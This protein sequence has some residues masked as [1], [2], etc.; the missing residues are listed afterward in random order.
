M[1]AR[2]F[3]PT[4]PKAVLFDMDDTIFDHSLTCRDALAS[5]RQEVPLLRRRPTDELWAEYGRLLELVQPEIARGT[6]TIDEARTARFGEL[7]R[8]CGGSATVAEARDW[9]RRYRAHYQSRRRLV[10]GARRL[11]ERLHGRAVIG[12]V[13]NNSVAEQ[14]EKVAHF[15]LEGLLDFMLVSEGVGVS[16]PDPQ[17]FSLA[18]ERA[19]AEPEE[20]VMLG[21]SWENDVRGARGVGIPAVWFNRFGRPPPE[22]LRIPQVASYQAP[23]RVEAVLSGALRP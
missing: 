19:A 20:A 3:P 15:G 12:V 8:F 21:D 13:T 7:A 6:R 2:E 5:L 22:P 23:R 18:L 1:S 17:I 14:E 9:S 16:K 10:P 11:L 4:L